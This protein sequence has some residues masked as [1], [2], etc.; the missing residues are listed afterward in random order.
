MQILPRPSRPGLGSLPTA[1]RSSDRARNA[2]A[3]RCDFSCDREPEPWAAWTERRIACWW[4]PDRP[5]SGCGDFQRRS[6]TAIWTGRCAPKRRWSWVMAYGVLPCPRA[7][8]ASLAARTTCWSRTPGIRRSISSGSAS[9]SPGHANG[10]GART[11]RVRARRGASARRG[12]PLHRGAVC[13]RPERAPRAVAGGGRGGAAPRSRA[14]RSGDFG[15]R[16]AW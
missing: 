10:R 14:R 2:S 7:D 16:R 3:C 5:P 4:H 8:P 11:H 15:I 1:P 6:S 13:A 9:R 12:R